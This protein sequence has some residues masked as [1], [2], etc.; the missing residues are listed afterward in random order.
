M[1]RAE[2]DALS[3]ELGQL[4]KDATA[5]AADADHCNEAREASY[6]RGRATAF[7]ES[8]SML[9]EALAKSEAMT[10]NACVS[11]GDPNHD[12]RQCEAI[13]EGTNVQCACGAGYEV[14]P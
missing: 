4:A 2:I 11:C 14:T 9:A 7:Y 12:G 13:I 5:H 10:A 1:N 3:T 8:A 6:M